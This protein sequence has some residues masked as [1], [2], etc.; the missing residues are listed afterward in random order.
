MKEYNF[1]L[2]CYFLESRSC[3]LRKV[4]EITTVNANSN[5]SVVKIIKSHG[6]STEVQEPTPGTHNNIMQKGL[7]YIKRMLKYKCIIRAY[8]SDW[9][10][11]VSLLLVFLNKLIHFRFKT[12]VHFIQRYHKGQ[13]RHI[14]A[15]GTVTLLHSTS[16]K[17][18]VWVFS[19]TYNLHSLT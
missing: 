19:I 2:M 11:S 1:L 8:C 16:M 7:I 5:G 9:Q 13:I 10:D 17:I 6:N 3:Q 4:S 18:S 14:A 12:E 15:V